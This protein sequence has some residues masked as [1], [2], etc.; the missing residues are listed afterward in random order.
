M[1][2]DNMA[3]FGFELEFESNAQALATILANTNLS[4]TDLNDDGGWGPN[5]EMIIGDSTLH[6]YHCEC[7]TCESHAFRMQRDSSCSG[8]LISN[9]FTSIEDIRPY[10]E[11]IQEACFTADAEPG[12]TAGLHVHVARDGSLARMNR[13]DAKRLWQWLRFEPAFERI[14]YGRFNCL[15]DFN[16]PTRTQLRDFLTYCTGFDE[17]RRIVR[18]EHNWFAKLDDLIRGMCDE[19]RDLSLSSIYA[20]SNEWDRHGYVATRTRHNTWEFRIWNST[21]VAWRMELFI[22]LSR[23]WMTDEFVENL[24]ELSTP[25]EE[26]SLDYVRQVLL[27]MM[28]EGIAELL[29]RQLTASDAALSGRYER[30]LTV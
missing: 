18:R 17:A 5:G 4:N 24:N 6:S 2:N 27:P 12:M 10:L 3:Q 1:P 20:F 13:S 15:R 21:R 30:R 23:L 11:A 28:P 8:E 16:T 22:Q 9:I 25:P 29:D 14:A 7:G 19:D 26:V